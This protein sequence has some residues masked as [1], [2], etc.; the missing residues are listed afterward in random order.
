LRRL[1]REP[2]PGPDRVTAPAVVARLID[3]R[4]DWSAELARR[5]GRAVRIEPS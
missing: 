2:L 1:E 4:E 3:G 5:R